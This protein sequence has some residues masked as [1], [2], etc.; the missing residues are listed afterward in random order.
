MDSDADLAELDAAFHTWAAGPS[1]RGVQRVGDR[2][3]VTNCVP[4]PAPPL[5]PPV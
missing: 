3:D 2:L 4:L 1:E 5:V